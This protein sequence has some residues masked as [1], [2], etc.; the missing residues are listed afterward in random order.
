MEAIINGRR[1][2]YLERGR[3][4]VLVLVHGFPLDATLWLDQLEALADL[5]RVVAVDLRGCGGSEAVTGAGLAMELLASDLDHLADH[6]GA[7][8]IDLAGLSMGGYVALA[9]AELFGHRLRS[10]ALLNTKAI[11]DDEEAKA[12]RDFLAQ[13]AVGS[14]RA[15]L[16]AEMHASLLGP[17]ASITARARLRTMVERTPYETLLACLIGMRDRSDRT[18]VLGS[19]AVPTLVVTGA[20]DSLAPEETAR[21]MAEAIPHGDL[22]VI[23]GVGHLTPIEAPEA[24][25]TALRSHLVRVD[26]V[27]RGDPPPR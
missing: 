22:V 10:L 24:V 1:M 14:G 7:E 3:G 6:L 26:G 23:P 16:G 19:L 8:R 25:S 18:H 2:H 21:E 27:R 5:R 4:D 20:E 11:G 15:L 12:S 13:T 17:G 9:F